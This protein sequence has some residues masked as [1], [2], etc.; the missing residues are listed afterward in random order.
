MKTRS[1]EEMIDEYGAN[2]I[3]SDDLKERKE[4]LS[5][6]SHSTIVEGNFFEFDNAEKWIKENL[7][8]DTINSLFYGKTDYDHGFME[9]FFDREADSER[10]KKEVMNIY[11]TY[12]DGSCSKSDGYGHDIPFKG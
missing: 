6:Q 7:H 4:I 12:P 5:R 3:E 1:F 10:F 9:Y 8:I 11:T 2:Q